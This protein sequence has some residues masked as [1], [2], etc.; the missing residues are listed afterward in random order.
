MTHKFPRAGFLIVR[1]SCNF[2]DALSVRACLVVQLDGDRAEVITR[3]GS[4]FVREWVPMKNVASSLTRLAT[5]I[6]PF[7]S[8]LLAR[9]PL[10]ATAVM[11]AG[12]SEADLL[13]AAGLP[14]STQTPAAPAAS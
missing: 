4:N 12:G 6:D 8:E 2:T 14:A 13:N 3:C 11:T 5:R 7:A 1:P 9:A 10:P